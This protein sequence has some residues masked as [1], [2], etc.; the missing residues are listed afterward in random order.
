MTRKQALEC[1][2]ELAGELDYLQ[3]KYLNEVD[4]HERFHMLQDIAEE[5]EDALEEQS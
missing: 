3:Q 5:A 1:I 4:C 2:A